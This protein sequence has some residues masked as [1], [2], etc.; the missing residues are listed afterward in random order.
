MGIIYLIKVPLCISFNIMA[1]V[2][3]RYQ[4]YRTRCT[5]AS[6]SVGTYI[7]ENNRNSD[8]ILCLI[9]TL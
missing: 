7:L 5:G 8:S 1:I 3:Y 4:W 6:V 2:W 9:Y